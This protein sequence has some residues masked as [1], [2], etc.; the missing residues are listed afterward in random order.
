MHD[1]CV[2]AISKNLGNSQKEF[3]SNNWKLVSLKMPL[4]HMLSQPDLYILCKYIYICILTSVINSETN[5]KIENGKGSRH[6]L[7][8]HFPFSK[9]KCYFDPLQLKENH[10]IYGSSMS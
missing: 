2:P 4:I 9:R 1:V 6:V 7:L 8:D 10:I 3:H 5:S